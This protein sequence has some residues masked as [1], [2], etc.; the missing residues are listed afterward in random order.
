M[1]LCFMASAE[2]QVAT[3][4]VSVEDHFMDG[5]AESFSLNWASNCNHA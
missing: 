1:G 4:S 3:S 5:L 2:S